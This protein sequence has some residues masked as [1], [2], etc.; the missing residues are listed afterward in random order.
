ML[1]LRDGYLTG[2]SATN[3][4]F[5]PQLPSSGR[6]YYELFSRTET[7]PMTLHVRVRRKAREV[8]VLRLPSCQVQAATAKF[9]FSFRN[10][11]AKDGPEFVLCAESRSERDEWMDALTEGAQGGNSVPSLLPMQGWMDKRKTETKG[12]KTKHKRRYCILSGHTLKYYK[13]QEADPGRNVATGVLDTR[14]AVEIDVLHEQ[15]AHGL[16]MH[17]EKVTFFLR[18]DP[19]EQAAWISVLMANL[20]NSDTVFTSEAANVAAGG[21]ATDLEETSDT[22]ANEPD[23]RS[24]HVAAGQAFRM[25]QPTKPPSDDKADYPGPRSSQ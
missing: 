19:E 12:R 11:H 21:G 5:F 18:C 17:F 16:E 24:T 15:G 25:P 6:L 23:I 10:D 8:E 20:Q 1:M 4:H 13:K 14:E 7:K 22:D 3:R 9:G 2:T